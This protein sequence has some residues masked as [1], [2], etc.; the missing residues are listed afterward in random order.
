MEAKKRYILI[1]NTWL[2]WTDFNLNYMGIHNF[3]EIP[4]K[5]RIDVK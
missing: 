3:T 4:L 2:N 5:F 1:F